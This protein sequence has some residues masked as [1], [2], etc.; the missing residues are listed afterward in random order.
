MNNWKE[1][2]LASVAA[3]AVLA[4]CATPSDVRSTAPALQINS[5]RP[6]RNVAGCIADRLEAQYKTGISSRPTSGGY[7]V[8]K[9]DDAGILGKITG[10]VFDVVES[11]SGSKVSLY[12]KG[13]LQSAADSAVYVAKSC[14]T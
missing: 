2:L 5:D 11:G 7:T 4:G 12:T 8:W 3:T 13:L 1:I 10:M 9:E 14:S 6:A